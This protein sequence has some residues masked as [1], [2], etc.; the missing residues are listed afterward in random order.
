MALQTS[1]K[2][3]VRMRFINNTDK[4]FRLSHAVFLK[5][6]YHQALSDG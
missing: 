3:F 4:E 6:E 1:L 5:Y 2:V